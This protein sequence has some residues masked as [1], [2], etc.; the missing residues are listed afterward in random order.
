[1]F[2]RYMSHEIRTPLNTVMMGL[3]HCYE[4]MKLN[5]TEESKLVVVEDILESCGVAIKTL[6]DMLLFDKIEAGM[7]VLDKEEIAILPILEKT[8]KLFQVQVS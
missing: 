1:M 5:G 6:N 3:E 8:V 7:L 4:G 2:V